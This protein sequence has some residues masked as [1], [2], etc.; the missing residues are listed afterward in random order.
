MDNRRRILAGGVGHLMGGF[1]YNTRNGN[2]PFSAK[3][4][5]SCISVPIIHLYKSLLAQI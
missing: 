2:N 1:L 4:D 5:I 3:A